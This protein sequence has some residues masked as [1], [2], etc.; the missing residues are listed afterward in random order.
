MRA[1]LPAAR[2]AAGD[3]SVAAFELHEAWAAAARAGPTAL[4]FAGHGDGAD[5]RR[6]VELFARVHEPDGDEVAL[7]Q[8]ADGRQQRGHV[9]A[10]HPLPAPR[11]EHG[12][13]FVDNEA[14]IAAAAEH[15]ADHARERQGP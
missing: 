1:T 6:Q 5:F 7:D 13:E 11:I 12:L 2:E 14:H 15:G 8:F 9:A 10:F 3:A 4:A